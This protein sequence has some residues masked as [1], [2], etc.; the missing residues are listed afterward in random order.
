M[1][2]FPV[3]DANFF[4]AILVT[5]LQQNDAARLQGLFV[6][7]TNTFA[8]HRL[9]GSWKRNAVGSLDYKIAEGKKNTLSSLLL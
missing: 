7:C 6:S 5:M 1:H 4:I 9:G 2:Q 3:K 8:A